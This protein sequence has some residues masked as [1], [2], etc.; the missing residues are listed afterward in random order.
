MH[1]L[2][3]KRN[4]IFLLIRI[5]ALIA[6]AFFISIIWTIYER[7]EDSKV[8]AWTKESSIDISQTNVYTIP[9]L[10][11]VT[12]MHLF[13]IHFKAPLLEKYNGKQEYINSKE[14]DKYLPGDG[15]NLEWKIERAGS[16]LSEG[17][18]GPANFSGWTYKDKT[19]FTCTKE[20]S[21]LKRGKKYLFTIKVTKSNP[22]VAKFNPILRISTWIPKGHGCYDYGFPLT[23]SSIFLIGLIVE[24]YVRTRLKKIYIKS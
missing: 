3:G 21:E 14:I 24:D 6:L 7:R 5:C 22:E 10:P 4:L 2:P 19:D 15:F 17:T 13:S 20:I 23:L 18:L 1:I 8:R 12:R 9:L 16:V 11:V